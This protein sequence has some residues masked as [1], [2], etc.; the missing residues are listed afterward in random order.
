MIN[1]IFD[2]YSRAIGSTWASLLFPNGFQTSE[3]RNWGVGYELYTIPDVLNHTQYLLNSYYSLPFNSVDSLAIHNDPYLVDG[4]PML[5]VPTLDMTRSDSEKGTSGSNVS[6]FLLE[7]PDTG[8]PLAPDSAL[9]KA[10]DNGDLSYTEDFFN[11]LISLNFKVRIKKGQ[12][13]TTLTP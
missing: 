2:D 1:S 8:W 9:A 7:S 4:D 13:E 12:R 3:E 6:T 10:Y 5:G 11:N